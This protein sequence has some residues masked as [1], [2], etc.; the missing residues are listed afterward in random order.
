M[1]GC[2]KIDSIVLGQHAVENNLEERKKKKRQESV[3]VLKSVGPLRIESLEPRGGI[4]WNSCQ[5]DI[6]KGH[7]IW[8]TTGLWPVTL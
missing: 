7:D 2:S 4:A 6:Q 1:K 8:F 5:D 3:A